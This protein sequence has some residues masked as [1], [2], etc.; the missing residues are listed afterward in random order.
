MERPTPPQGF[1]DTN[2][3]NNS[4]SHSNHAGQQ[5]G[6][7]AFEALRTGVGQGLES[8]R[9]MEGMQTP[10][11]PGAITNPASYRPGAIGNPTAEGVG[12]GGGAEVGGGRVGGVGDG[13]AVPL[14]FGQSAG[15]FQ[16]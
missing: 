9:G 8:L 2:T 3:T 10:H 15:K 5:V 11:P 13:R 1:L 7:A 16:L 4:N 12:E 14:A 6:Q